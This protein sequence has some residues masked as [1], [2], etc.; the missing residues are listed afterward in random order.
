MD[1]KKLYIFPHIFMFNI[2]CQYAQ[3]PFN[4]K[5]PSLKSYNFTFFLL[6]KNVHHFIFYSLTHI[7]PGTFG[8]Y[9]LGFKYN[10]D[11][12]Q[13]TSQN[14]RSPDFLSLFKVCIFWHIFHLSSPHI[15]SGPQIYFPVKLCLQCKQ[16]K[17]TSYLYSTVHP[18]FLH[19]HARSG[20]YIT[21]WPTYFSNVY[22]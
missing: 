18:C 20:K 19:I 6:W 7:S 11:S 5:S 15:I 22:R 13:C 14:H 21:N 3:I 12:S 8:Q 1:F 10:P 16:G 4:M 17:S 2:L 9:I